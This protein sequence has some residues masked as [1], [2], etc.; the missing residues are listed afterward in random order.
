M[1]CVRRYI[2]L[3]HT[4]DLLSCCL[5]VRSWL[6]ALGFGPHLKTLEGADAYDAVFWNLETRGGL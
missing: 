2:G 3:G 1:L 6:V 5:V 4:F